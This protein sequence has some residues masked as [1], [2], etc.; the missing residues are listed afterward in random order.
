MCKFCVFIKVNSNDCK[1]AELYCW[2]L[3]TV[4]GNLASVTVK[5]KATGPIWFW[6]DNYLLKYRGWPV[7]AGYSGLNNKAIFVNS[8]LVL[9]SVMWESAPGREIDLWSDA[10]GGIGADCGAGV[11]LLHVKNIYTYNAT[12]HYYCL[13]HDHYCPTHMPDRNVSVS[14]PECCQ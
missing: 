6:D 4:D 8:L 10:V 5:T 2:L 12:F 14:G 11:R 7:G 9:V 1:I 13:R 3:L